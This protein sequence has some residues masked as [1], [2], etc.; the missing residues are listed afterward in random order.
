M[1][2]LSIFTVTKLF[3]VLL[4][5]LAS[6]PL[7]SNVWAAGGNPPDTIVVSFGSSKMYMVVQNMQDREMLKNMNLNEIVQ[8]TVATMDSAQKSKSNITN[9][10]ALSST[11]GQSTELSVGSGGSSTTARVRTTDRDGCF[12]YKEQ[13]NDKSNTWN[14]SSNNNSESHHDNYDND[15]EK[16]SYH[17]FESVTGFYLGLNNFVADSKLVSDTKY[18]LNPLGSRYVGFFLGQNVALGHKQHTPLSLDFG[19]GMNWNNFMFQ[20]NVEIVKNGN[21]TEFVDSDKD[22]RKSKVTSYYLYAPVM[23][24]YNFGKKKSHSSRNGLYV[25]AGAY[26]GYRL[27]TYSKQV[28]YSTTD[29]KQKDHFRSD[30]NF[31][32]IRYGLAAEI[33]LGSRYGTDFALFG[34][35][36]LSP[37]FESGQGPVVNALNFGLRI[38]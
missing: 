5:F 36:D 32:N 2:K 14:W 16:P 25:A 33:G 7:A 18:S 27:N 21:L 20:E 4:S 15:E 26:A 30:Y 6:L 19:L 38:F 3:A 11:T 17:R 8:K 1:K 35:Y 37:V 9:K 10:Q 28:Y 24:K 13:K 34:S 31:N 12:V 29:G 22:L 23:L